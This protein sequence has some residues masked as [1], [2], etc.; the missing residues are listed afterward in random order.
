MVDT[1]RHSSASKSRLR[2]S[3][4]D[5]VSVWS[6]LFSPRSSIC[7]CRSVDR[8]VAICCSLHLTLEINSL[9][10]YHNSS[11][12][13][14]RTRLPEIARNFLVLV[15]N[16]SLLSN[17]SVFHP[18]LYFRRREA[19][20]LCDDLI[21]RLDDS[22]SLGTMHDVAP[23]NVGE[24]AIFTSNWHSFSAALKPI[25]IFKYKHTSSIKL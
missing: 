3:N 16:C 2:Q 20:W 9:L 18:R 10:L 17:S 15:F 8:P 22:V 6:A 21:D 5:V 25:W 23:L 12:P 1:T 4:L 11:Q 13:Y 7:S 14:R 24:D 19:R